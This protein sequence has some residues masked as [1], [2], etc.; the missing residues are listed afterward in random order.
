MYYKYML[1]ILMFFKQSNGDYMDDNVSSKYDKDCSNF[2]QV[3]N[4]TVVIRSDELS[5][6]SVTA[7]ITCKIGFD[8]I[9]PPKVLCID[10]KWRDTIHHQCIAR[11]KKPPFISNGEVQIEGKSDEYNMYGKGVVATYSCGDG[12]VLTPAESTYRICEKGVWSGDTGICKQI[13]CTRPENIT[14]GIIDLNSDIKNS[15]LDYYESGYKVQY[16]C[17]PGYFNRGPSVQ[18]CQNGVWLPK[19]GPKCVQPGGKS[20]FCKTII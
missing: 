15:D 3:D 6:Y 13:A 20:F 17:K 12:F 5:D 1:M 19:P 18:T 2:P 8:L 7:H 16:W 9:G 14:N 11:C 10:G 4:G